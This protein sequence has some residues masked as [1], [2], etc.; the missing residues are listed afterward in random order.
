MSGFLTNSGLAKL[1]VATPLTP[2]TVKYMAFDS[3]EGTPTPTMNALFNEVYRTEIP[4]P[5]KDPDQPKNLTFSG[6]VPTTVGGWTVYGIGLFDSLN[7][8]VA[9]LQ[10]AEPVLKTDPSSALKMSWQQDFIIT[11]ANAGETDLII[12]DSVEFRHDSLTNRNHPDAHNIASITGLQDDLDD[13]NTR[14]SGIETTIVDLSDEVNTSISLDRKVKKVTA[15]YTVLNDD[16]GLLEIDASAGSITINMPKSTAFIAKEIM[17]HRTDAVSAN[18]VTIVAAPGDT[19]RGEGAVWSAMSI[20][21]SETILFRA[22]VNLFTA[23]RGTVVNLFRVSTA[24]PF[25]IIEKGTVAGSLVLVDDLATTA[26]QGVIQLATNAEV[27]TGTNATKAVTPSAYWSA[28]IGWGQTWQ[29]VTASRSAGVS[30]TNS[31]GRPIQVAVSI[32]DNGQTQTTWAIV[33]GVTIINIGDLTGGESSHTAF[34][35]IVPN[36][37]TYSVNGS[38]PITQWSELR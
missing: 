23:I 17:L 3:G 5:V 9:Y 7:V 15:N 37:A 26:K 25:S 34:S 28:T 36:G 2:M 33:S 32:K 30:Y 10:L 21:T 13:K 6:F 18:I 27:V 19:Y 38:N 22:G 24:D 35:F 11:L 12:T 14:M 31:T 20:L 8:L 29:S 16:G 1:A 4:N